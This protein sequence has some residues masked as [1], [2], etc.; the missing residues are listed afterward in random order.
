MFVSDRLAFIEL[1]KTG[2][3]HIRGL[4]KELVGGELAGKHNQ[5]D[6]ELFDGRRV[7]LGSVR[8][9]WDWYVSLWAYGCDRKGIVYGNVTRGGLKLRGHGW[10]DDP[11]LAVRELLAARPN[12]HAAEWQR[13]YRDASDAGA[14]RQWLRMMHDERYWSDFGQG[15]GRSRLSRLA[16]LFTWRYMKLFA[17]RDGESH[18]LDR[19]SS[20]E[21]LVEHDR[22]HGFIDH[23]IRNEHL[24]ADLFLALERS[25]F[26]VDADTKAEILA[27][28]R[29]NTSSRRQGRGYYYD[30]ATA[31][32]VGERDRLLVEKFGY[33]APAVP[34]LQPEPR[35]AEPLRA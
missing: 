10:R 19:I 2:C 18:S 28:A 30:D 31:R 22:E 3:T 8:D 4:L 32:L 12:A 29:T 33:A 1:H 27:R 14:F 6:A 7:F 35:P 11:W 25:G 5:A 20:F 17:C 15:Y 21:Q 23:F 24:E 26:E 9:P 34:R 13:T 16:G